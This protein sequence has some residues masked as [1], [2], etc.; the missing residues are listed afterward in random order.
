MAHTQHKKS[1]VTTS[2]NHYTSTSPKHTTQE[3]KEI[4]TITQSLN[5]PIYSVYSTTVK[6]YHRGYDFNSRQNKESGVR[7]DCSELASALVKQQI[8]DMKNASDIKWKTDFSSLEHCFP[9][10][11]TTLG[12]RAAMDKLGI[13]K[14][15]H[16]S[17]NSVKNTELKP[18]MMIYLAYPQTKSGYSRHVATVT[19]NPQTGELMISESIGGKNN[20]GVVH[21]SVNDFFH[22][23]KAI[24]NPKTTVTVYDPFYKDRK[25]LDQLDKEASQIRVLYKE[26]NQDYKHWG[27]NFNKVGGHEK[28]GRINFI[29]NY[30]KNKIHN[31]GITLENNNTDNTL[32]AD[33]S[34]RFTREQV[35]LF[36]AN[37]IGKFNNTFLS[38]LDFA[39]NVK[40]H[41]PE[42]TSTPNVH[43]KIT[44][45]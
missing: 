37:Q 18:G 19:R 5:N 34:N 10:G 3:A 32:V 9:Q 38:K 6:N 33:N 11:S 8:T 45:T 2:V 36:N 43:N 12:Q 1:R 20:I 4:A 7:W 44:L 17:R 39:F 25:Q 35:N 24:N 21:R 28:N 40:S 29:E 16:G 15:A 41:E 31:N 13:E 26:A 14:V 27:G 22:K 23:G 30:I 42:S